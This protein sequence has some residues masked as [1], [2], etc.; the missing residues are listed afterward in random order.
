MTPMQ[1]TL[2]YLRRDGYLC[3]ITEH[4]NPHV[5]VR[6]DLFGFADLIAFRGSETIA[7]QCCT[8]GDIN[9]RTRKVLDNETAEA[10]VTGY[11]RDLIV[12]GWKR[13]AKMLDRRWWRPTFVHLNPD[14][15]WN[16]KSR[17]LIPCKLKEL[18]RR[19]IT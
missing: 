15:F 1:R 18:P 9:N 8:T 13:Y 2:A 14:D 10:W 5:E 17:G 16:H 19:L 6:Q 12:I 11:Y 7:V 3:G 4:W